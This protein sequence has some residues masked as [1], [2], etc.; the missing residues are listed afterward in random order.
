MSPDLNFSVICCSSTRQR[1]TWTRR[2]GVRWSDSFS[3]IRLK[4]VWRLDGNPPGDCSELESVPRKASFC[5]IR[6]FGMTP[7]ERL[8]PATFH[9]PGVLVIH[10]T[11]CHQR[12]VYLRNKR[13][14]VDACQ[15]EC[16]CVRKREISLFIRPSVRNWIASLSM[17]QMS[18]GEKSW[19]NCCRVWGYNSQGGES[20]GKA[21]QSGRQGHRCHFSL[22]ETRGKISIT[23]PPP[24]PPCF[25]SVTNQ[26][27][28]RG[29]LLW[30][31]WH[32]RQEMRLFF[33]FKFHIRPSVSLFC[34]IAFPLNTIRGTHGTACLD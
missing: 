12:G 7:F 2:K 11:C 17:H 10:Q 23:P 18:E 30:L 1:R 13:R 3:G 29:M 33:F 5:E 28:L 9:R 4:S 31:S 21:G 20:D 32:V 25:P 34:F 22:H 16:I 8:P 27:D 24:P 26:E 15:K 14:P 19:P 6:V